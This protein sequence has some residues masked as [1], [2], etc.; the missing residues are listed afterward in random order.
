MTMMMTMTKTMKSKA[1]EMQTS[2]KDTA[3]PSDEIEP[4]E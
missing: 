2:L 4:E 3:K 1:A